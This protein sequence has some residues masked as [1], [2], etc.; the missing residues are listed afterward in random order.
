[1]HLRHPVL[2]PIW[3]DIHK[4]QHQKHDIKITD[5]QKLKETHKNRKE[6]HKNWKRPTKIEKRPTNDVLE[7]VWWDVYR[8]VHLCWYD[9]LS[10]WLDKST[11]Q[12][13]S[14][15]AVSVLQCVTVCCSMLQCFA[16]SLF[17]SVWQVN[18]TSY[19]L[20]TYDKS[21]TTYNL[22][23]WFK[24]SAHRDNRVVDLTSWLGKLSPVKLGASKHIKSN[25]MWIYVL[26]SWLDKLS[27]SDLKR[28]QRRGWQL[29]LT[30]AT[31]SSWLGKFHL[32]PKH[33]C[34]TLDIYQK[35]EIQKK[36][37]NTSPR[38]VIWICVLHYC[39]NPSNL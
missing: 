7:P 27:L 29:N 30:D 9:D 38:L 33:K 11:W 22:S 24:F 36:E 35:K 13:I 17:Q 18:L 16:V 8:V 26:T 2:E 23:S 12:V 20:S 19:K 25:L 28:G 6:T 21:S 39:G 1:M 3:R 15:V 34:R 37:I 31:L 10:R 5:P 14:C 32:C 4:R